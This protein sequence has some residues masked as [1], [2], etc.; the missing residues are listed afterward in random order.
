MRYE[1]TRAAALLAG[2]GFGGLLD[3]ILL[4]QIG[5]WHHTVSA[6]L[7]P[8]TIDA[9]QLNLLADG[10]FNLILW[11]LVIAGVLMLY[12]S[13][14][15]SGPV[16]SLRA[17]AGY[18]L[19]GWG[20]F[21]L[22]EGALNHHVFD[23]HHVRDLPNPLPTYDWVYLVLAGIGFIVIGLAIRDGKSRA[24]APA[25]ERRSGRDRRLAY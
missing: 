4:Q 7:S 5:Q 21:N 25:I 8:V 22:A 19:I 9:L 11:I 18:L 10:L 15:E 17:F 1:R 24:P 2:A 13:L 6:R 14:R 16:P 20:A 3:G 23:L 12:S